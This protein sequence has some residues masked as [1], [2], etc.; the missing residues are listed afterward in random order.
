MTMLVLSVVVLMTMMVRVATPMMA[1]LMATV[2][3]ASSCRVSQKDS[4]G[5]VAE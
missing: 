3:A 5:R 2:I 1:M 4:S